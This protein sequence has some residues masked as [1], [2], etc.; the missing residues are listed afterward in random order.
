MNKTMTDN[1]NVEKVHVVYKSHFDIGF[2]NSAQKMVHD[3]V[4]WQI[5]VAADLANQLRQ[6]GHDKSYVR[7]AGCTAGVFVAGQKWK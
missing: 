4:N 6:E 1:A 2:T 5:D 3:I 7:D